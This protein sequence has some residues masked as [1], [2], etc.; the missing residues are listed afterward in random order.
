MIFLKLY[1]FPTNPFS[2]II[3]NDRTSRCFLS[4]QI[5]H[6]Q[7]QEDLISIMPMVNEANA[8]SEELDK[9]KAF[10]IAL[11]SPQARGLAGW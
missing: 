10:E 9:K 5:V 6:Y 3:L 2:Q 8:I 4:S 1:L 7:F 11:V